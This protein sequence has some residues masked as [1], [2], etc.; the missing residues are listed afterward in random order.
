MSS[1]HSDWVFISVTSTMYFAFDR[2]TCEQCTSKKR[3]GDVLVEFLEAMVINKNENVLNFTY[4]LGGGSYYF[5][6][7]GLLQSSD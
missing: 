5:H 1:Q 3:V 4:H 6:L 7:D 2:I